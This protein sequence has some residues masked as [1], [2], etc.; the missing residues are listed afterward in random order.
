MNLL[1]LLLSIVSFASTNTLEFE[2]RV[3]EV[4]DSTCKL[5]LRCGSFSGSRNLMASCQQPN[6]S[7]GLKARLRLERSGNCDLKVAEVVRIL[8]PL[9]DLPMDDLTNSEKVFLDNCP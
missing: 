5:C 4:K 7:S 1:F 6:L 3:V 9:E 8:S 2:V